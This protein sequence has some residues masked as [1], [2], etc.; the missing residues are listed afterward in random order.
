MRVDDARVRLDGTLLP[1]DGG[2]GAPRV[3]QAPAGDRVELSAA[4]RTL[5]GLRDEI[6]ALDEVREERIAGLRPVVGTGRYRVETE[7][8]ARS[9]LVEELGGLLA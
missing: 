1:P 2:V 3:G 9:L 6:G 8:V 4:A 7:T 5:A